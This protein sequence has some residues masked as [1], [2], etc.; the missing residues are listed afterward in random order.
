MSLV[1]T[2]FSTL[3]LNQR[4]ADGQGMI[5]NGPQVSATMHGKL[6]NFR[7]RW[8]LDYVR[9][10]IGFM[11]HRPLRWLWGMPSFWEAPRGEVQ[12]GQVQLGGIVDQS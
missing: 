4:D 9:Q 2:A 11:P 8:R 1:A 5:P 3:L 10:D 7:I 12:D 6:G